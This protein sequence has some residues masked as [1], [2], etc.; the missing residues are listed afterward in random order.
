VEVKKT[1][2]VKKN[3]TRRERIVRA[4]ERRASLS[5][6]KMARDGTAASG[7]TREATEKLR[8][9]LDVFARAGLKPDREY[10]ARTSWPNR[11]SA[12]VKS[13]IQRMEQHKDQKPRRHWTD[14][15]VR[16]IF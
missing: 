3:E 14:E 7:W 9:E 6:Q 1:N 10:I 2:R 5:A 15:E 16:I 13:K 8:G 11:S 4:Y 12:A